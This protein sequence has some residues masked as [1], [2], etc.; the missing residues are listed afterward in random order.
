MSHHIN[1]LE[2]DEQIGQV[3]S[4]KKSS[5]NRLPE[6]AVRKLVAM[7]PS[8]AKISR[9]SPRSRASPEAVEP[10]ESSARQTRPNEPNSP[11]VEAFPSQAIS[12]T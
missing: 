5:L 9:L 12:T 4:H 10:E 11:R 1:T 6:S 2:E 8:R 3:A 7:L